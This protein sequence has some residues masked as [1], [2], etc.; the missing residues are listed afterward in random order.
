MADRQDYLVVGAL[1]QPREFIEHSLA[2]GFK[3]GF[4][5]IEK[6]VSREI[7]FLRQQFF[8]R[9]LDGGLG[10]FFCR[11]V[12]RRRGGRGGRVRGQGGGKTLSPPGGGGPRRG[13]VARAGGKPR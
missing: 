13:A 9:R 10:R 5:E 2:I 3:F 11:W 12:R 7:D 4:V 6:R 1:Q 8:G